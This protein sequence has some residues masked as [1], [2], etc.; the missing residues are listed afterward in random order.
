MNNKEET[1]PIKD[2]DRKIDSQEN[3]GTELNVEKN[4]ENNTEDNP[5]NNLEKKN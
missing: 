4:L 1:T 2:Q 3:N 5:E